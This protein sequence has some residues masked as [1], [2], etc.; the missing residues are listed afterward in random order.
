[1]IIDFI[2]KIS[3]LLRLLQELL[4]LRAP[5]Y[6]HHRLIVDEAGKKFSKRNEAVTLRALRATG[7]TP[8]DIRKRLA[9]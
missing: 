2:R 5:V 7:A 6:A 8:A 3:T 9:F 4:D 1:L